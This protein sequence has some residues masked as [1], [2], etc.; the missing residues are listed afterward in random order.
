MAKPEPGRDIMVRY[1]VTPFEQ[2]VPSSKVLNAEEWDQIDT[3]RYAT[4]DDLEF[5]YETDVTEEK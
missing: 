1:Y 5:A 3:W 2:L 4:D